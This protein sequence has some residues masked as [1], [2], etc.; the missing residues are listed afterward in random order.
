MDLSGFLTA[1]SDTAKIQSRRRN[2]AQLKNRSTKK[3]DKH[4]NTQTQRQHTNSQ[5]RKEFLRRKVRADR[6]V[7]WRPTLVFQASRVVDAALSPM[8]FLTGVAINRGSLYGV[9][10]TEQTVLAG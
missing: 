7:W 9:I 6:R 3:V 4:P 1:A 10:P 5:R 2:T 8:G